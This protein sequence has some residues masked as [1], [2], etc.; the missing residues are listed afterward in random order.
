MSKSKANA[1][2]RRPRR[3]LLVALVVGV[4]V[5]AAGA[6]F[7]AYQSRAASS[8]LVGGAIVSSPQ[9]APDFTLPDQF[10]SAQSL[11]SLRGKPV[12]LTFIY[13]NCP[14]VCPLISAHMHQAY[15]MLGS[16]A[17]KVGIVAVTVDPERDN[18]QQIRSYSDRIGLTNEWHF[19]TGTRP[20]L[21]AV[22][23]SYGIDAQRVRATMSADTKNQPADAEADQIE[24]AAPVFMIDKRG[25]VRAMLPVDVSAEDIA[26]DLKVLLAEQG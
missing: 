20:Q 3:W 19:L 5:I 18:V 17:E 9:A 6:G 11:S 15:Q 22:W 13:T 25:Q 24:H 23:A 21:E 7:Y 1:S 26:A 2:A 8:E 14:D 4:L 12:A 16:Q 10:G